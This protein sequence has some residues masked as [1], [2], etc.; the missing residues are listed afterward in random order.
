MPLTPPQPIALLDGLITGFRQ[1]PEAPTGAPLVVYLHGGGSSALETIRPERSQLELA[2]RNG[3]P[4]FALNRPGYLDSASLG[5]PGDTDEG[6]FAASAERLLAAIGELWRRYGAEAPG[7]V[8]HGCSIGGAITLTLAAQWTAA[9][10]RGEH[11]WPLLGVAV[12]DIGQVPPEQ[13]RSRWRET[14]PAEYVP[15]LRAWFAGFPM[16]P[17]WTLP[18]SRSDTPARIPRDELLEVVGGWPRGWRAV[19]SAVGVPV[20]YRIGEYDLLWEVGEH[21]LEEMLAALRTRSPYVDGAIV[22]GAAHPIPAGPL[23]AAYDLGVL[24]F[25]ERCRVAASIPELLTDRRA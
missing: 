13:V 23:G 8:V 19:A 3:F 14:E 1:P 15:D 17:S 24:A 21:H 11:A 10:D 22:P 16:P 4:A 20:R 5:F 9:R 18:A 12:G 2:A 6:W 25:A 7:V